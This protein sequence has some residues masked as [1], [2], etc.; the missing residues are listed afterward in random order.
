MATD[1]RVLPMGDIE[2]EKQKME[3]MSYR[4]VKI[5]KNHTRTYITNKCFKCGGRGRI[6]YFYHVDGGICFQCGGSGV[7]GEN[8]VKIYTPEYF[9]KLESRRLEREKAKA[10]AENKAFFQKLG[11]SDSGKAWVILGETF[12]QKEEIKAAGGRFDAVYGWHFSQPVEGW[13]VLEITAAE[14][15]SQ[16]ESG[17]YCQD[18]E[19]DSRIKEAI[20]AANNKIAAATSRSQHIGQIGDKLEILLKL[21]KVCSFE[22]QWGLT[23]IYNFTDDSENVFIW[24]TTKELPEVTEGDKM[25]ITGSLKAHSEYKGICQNVLTRCKIKEV[26]NEEN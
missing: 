18:L 1:I 6:N 12:S 8:T 3:T 11:F 13:E 10:P 21:T 4:F 7:A 9:R 25:V 23:Y 22:S 20:K 19:K 16:N 17:R 24:K 26:K 14:A 5:D 2:A 15:F